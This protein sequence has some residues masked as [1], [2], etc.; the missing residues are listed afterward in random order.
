V[1]NIGIDLGG[2][3]IA[4]GLVDEGGVIISR[5]ETPTL[6][7]RPYQAIVK[8]MAEYSLRMLLECGKDLDEVSSIGIGIPGIADQHTG[9]VV[10]CTNL[11]WHDIPLRDELQ[12]YINKPVYIDN[13]ATIAGYAESK[14]G[15]SRDCDSSV[16]L[17]LGTGLGAGIIIQGKPWSGFHGVGSEFGH[18]TLVMD[19]VPC[20]CGN[21][22]CVERYCSATALI[23][24][25]REA[26]DANPD[27]AMMRVCNGDLKL[28]NAKIIIDAARDGDTT[29]GNV[30]DRYT[31]SLAAAINN[32]T[33]FLDPEMIVLGGGVSR[34]GNFLLSAVRAKLP[35]F[36]MYK[37]LQSPRLELAALGNEAGIIGAAFLGSI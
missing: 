5:A 18:T 16:F 21:K 15:I 26:C 10:F 28:I 32:I 22:G 7:G 23:R 8:D 9:R 34:A 13:D 11:S 6:A 37:T 25:A 36:L 17:T 4:A 1:Y 19:G 24:L 30:F 27:N 35:A 29:A 31:T 12:R 3:K 14:V 33:A 2:T 20:T